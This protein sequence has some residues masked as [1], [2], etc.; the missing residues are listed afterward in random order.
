MLY[1]PNSVDERARF[2]SN[3]SRYVCCN[4]RVMMLGDFNCVLSAGDRVNNAGVRDRSSEVLS[5]LINE[6]ELDD[7]YECLEGGVK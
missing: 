6:N 5:N 1:A 3:L 2:F 4:M 7:V